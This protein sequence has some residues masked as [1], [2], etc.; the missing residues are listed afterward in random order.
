MTKFKKCEI[1]CLKNTIAEFMVPRLKAFKDTTKSKPMQFKTMDDW[2]SVIDQMTFSFEN[3][4]NDDLD[5]EGWDKV[6][7]GLDLFREYYFD[8][9]S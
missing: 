6:E 5:D 4:D 3:Y 2:R 1:S 8:L 9:W 7:K